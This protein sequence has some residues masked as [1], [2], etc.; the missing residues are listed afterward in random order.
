MVLP[1]WPLILLKLP[2]ADLILSISVDAQPASVDGC[3]C[4]HAAESTWQVLIS[5][6]DPWEDAKN[7]STVGFYNPHHTSIRDQNWGVLYYFGFFHTV[8]YYTDQLH[9]AILY[10]TSPKLGVPPVGSSPGSGPHACSVR[11]GL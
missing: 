7:R 5:Y 10:H 6:T 11:R 9:H 2:H 4:G 8:L 3:F 1:L